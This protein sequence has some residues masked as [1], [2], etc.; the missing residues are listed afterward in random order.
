MAF[1]FVFGPA[2][3]TIDRP[4]INRH[5]HLIEPMCYSGYEGNLAVTP[6]GCPFLCTFDIEMQL[7]Q[8]TLYVKTSLYYSTAIYVYIYHNLC[9]I[10]LGISAR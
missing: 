5:L 2:D 7:K 4:K 10:S 8:L 3:A 9:Y 6:T 1:W